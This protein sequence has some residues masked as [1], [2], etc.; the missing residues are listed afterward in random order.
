MCQSLPPAGHLVTPQ[1]KAFSS[2]SQNQQQQQQALVLPVPSI[3]HV[4]LVDDPSLPEGAALW[5]CC[6]GD[7]QVRGNE[8]MINKK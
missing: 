2:D 1:L 8:V 4:T 7:A 6:E 5:V 3:V